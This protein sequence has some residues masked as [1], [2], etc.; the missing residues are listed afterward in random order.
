MI[1]PVLSIGDAGLEDE[2]YVCFR[3]RSTHGPKTRSGYG[4]LLPKRLCGTK[5]VLQ[6]LSDCSSRIL[7][8]LLLQQ[9]TARREK[10][11]TILRLEALQ[12]TALNQ[13]VELRQDTLLEQAA[14]LPW[15]IQLATALRKMEPLT[16]EWTDR[17]HG[18]ARPRSYPVRPT[19]V[20]PSQSSLARSSSTR[21]TELSLEALDSEPGG[22]STDA[23]EEC[24]A[25]GECLETFSSTRGQTPSAPTHFD[26]AGSS[27]GF[28]TPTGTNRPT[29]GSRSLNAIDSTKEYGLREPMHTG[30][31]PDITEASERRRGRRAMYDKDDEPAGAQPLAPQHENRE[32]EDVFGRSTGGKHDTNQES[33]SHSFADLIFATRPSEATGDTCNISRKP[34]S[35]RVHQPALAN[36]DPVDPLNASGL[37]EI[38]SFDLIRNMPYSMFNFYSDS[39]SAGPGSFNAQGGSS[40]NT[41]P[42]TSGSSRQDGIPYNE[43]AAT[44]LLTPR[45]RL[46]DTSRYPPTTNSTGARSEAESC[47]PVKSASPPKSRGS[48]K[49]SSF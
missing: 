24:R 41:A 34:L 36:Q 40:E 20:I 3:T 33:T 5:P 48:A 45:R 4:P 18:S 22:K 9:E 32:N 46:L 2:P 42:C 27:T 8:I 44:G 35:N 17:L 11:Q 37:R 30:R 25:S 23:E 12:V 38:L 19:I 28:T 1:I 47:S 31:N 15:A 43:P 16:E 13:E 7:R 6:K 26:A 10:Q 21:R 39:T 29:L 14:P 49:P